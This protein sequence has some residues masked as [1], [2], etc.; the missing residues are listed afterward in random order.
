MK[1]LP[2]P[3]LFA[4][5]GAG[6]LAGFLLAV[7]RPQM[8]VGEP[9]VR[10]I[11]LSMRDYTF[12]G[13]N[14]TLYLKPGERVRFVVRNDED[15]PVR[16]NFEIRELGILPGPEIGPGESREVTITVPLSGE[17]TYGCT[18]HRGMEGRIVIRNP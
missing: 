4:V 11:T 9:P 2:V 1:R 17:F 7:L 14:P 8:F 12:G 16:H 13:T 10:V 18:T 3:V 5:V 6:A 15:T